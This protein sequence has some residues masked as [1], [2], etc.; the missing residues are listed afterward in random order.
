M[1]ALCA[2]LIIMSNALASTQLQHCFPDVDGPAQAD[3]RPLCRYEWVEDGR[4][5]GFV[6]YYLFDRVAIITHTEVDP[7]I[8]GKGIGS[9]LVRRSLREFR[10]RGQ[11]VVP[12]CDFF[13]RVIRRE[14]EFRDCVAPGAHLPF[15]I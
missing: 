15:D 6:E 5:L 8:A 7:A 9:E 4:Q 12:V 14:A 3:Q 10:Q 1:S 2:S 13:A 11:R